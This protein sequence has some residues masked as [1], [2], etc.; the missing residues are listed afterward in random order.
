MKVLDDSSNHSDTIWCISDIG[1]EIVSINSFDNDIGVGESAASGGE[2]GEWRAC[3]GRRASRPVVRRHATRPPP[4]LCRARATNIHPTFHTNTIFANTPLLTHNHNWILCSHQTLR[5][6]QQG[7][8]I[9]HLLQSL[10]KQ[11]VLRRKLYRLPLI[12]VPD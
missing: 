3:R 9:G 12:I 1:S 2:G 8:Y 4:R 11:N 10:Y 7:K 6:S 5:R